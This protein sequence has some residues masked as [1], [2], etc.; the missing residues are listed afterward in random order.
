MT[1][2]RRHEI[3][4]R[5][6]KHFKGDASQTLIWF[7]DHQSML[8]GVTPNYLLKTEQFER[9]ENFI[10]KLENNNHQ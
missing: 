8:G 2:D 1:I 9:L 10:Q 5:V 7:T 6:L 3:Y 4:K